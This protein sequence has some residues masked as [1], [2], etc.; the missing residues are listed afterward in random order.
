MNIQL[1]K[2]PKGNDPRKGVYFGVKQTKKGKIYL[3]HLTKDIPKQSIDTSRGRLQKTREGRR[4]LLT[5]LR[6][7]IYVPQVHGSCVALPLEY[8]PKVYQSVDRQ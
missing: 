2:R 7:P 8:S 3:I 1:S 5:L 4:P 6:A